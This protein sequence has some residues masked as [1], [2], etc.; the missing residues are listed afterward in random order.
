MWRHRLKIIALVLVLSLMAPK[1]APAQ[2]FSPVVAIIVAA[3]NSINQALTTIIGGALDIMNRT[4]GAIQGLFQAVQD[5]FQKVVLSTSPG[6]TRRTRL[7]RAGHMGTYTRS[8]QS[9]RLPFHSA[10]LA[11]PRALEQKKLL[12]RGP[13]SH[14]E[15][16]G[17]IFCPST[18]PLPPATDASP[19]LR[20]VI[21]MSD[22]AA[23]AQ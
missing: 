8:G 19:E 13:L 5:L 11:S 1:P 17:T 7:G 4:L 9:L 16:F 10:T 21:D 14:P 12:S 18:M 6:S 20:D 3:L 22:A 23:Q 15:C 2:I